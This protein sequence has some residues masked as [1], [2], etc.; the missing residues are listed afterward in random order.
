MR[1]LS[2]IK[3]DLEPWTGSSRA[4]KQDQ[5]RSW[6][7]RR[8]CGRCSR[9][10]C[11]CVTERATDIRNDKFHLALEVPRLY[12]MTLLFLCE[13]REQSKH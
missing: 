5:K 10:S 1:C 9:Q 6:E 4:W 7:A 2:T 3:R 11:A 13:T 8:T 12:W